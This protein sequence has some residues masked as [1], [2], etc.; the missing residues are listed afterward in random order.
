MKNN[1]LEKLKESLNEAD[2]YDDDLT[3]PFTLKSFF[4]KNKKGISG[5]VCIIIS[6]LLAIITLKEESLL[7]YDTIV[8]IMM[9]VIIIYCFVRG[10]FT[11][12]FCLKENKYDLSVN[13]YIIIELYNQLFFLYERVFWIWVMIPLIL[14]VIPFMYADILCAYTFIIPL[15]VIVE[16]VLSKKIIKKYTKIKREINLKN[17]DCQW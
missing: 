3:I 11:L 6:V 2:T 17:N 10:I 15:V 16:I 1:L 5:I 12:L 14:L 9:V 7:E 8:V 4:H 13:K